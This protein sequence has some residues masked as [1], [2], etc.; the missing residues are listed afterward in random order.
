M[1]I[2]RDVRTGLSQGKPLNQIRTEVDRKYQAQ[3]YKP[4]DTPM[5]PAGK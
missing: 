2:T 3:G 1:D 5:P 4:T